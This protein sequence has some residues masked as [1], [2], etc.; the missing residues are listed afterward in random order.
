MCGRNAEGVNDKDGARA[1]GNGLLDGGRIEVERDGIDLGEDRCCAG[2][3]H[4]VGHGN[5]CERGNDDLMPPAYSQREQGQ[6]QTGCAGADGNSDPRRSDTRPA[7]L[8]RPR[9]RVQGS[10]AACA[11]RR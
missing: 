4:G 3:E 10:G 6:M 5:K 1:R 11:G 9:V 2:L 7:P 8:Q